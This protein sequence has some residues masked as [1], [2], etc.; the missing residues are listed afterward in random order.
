M[1]RELELLGDGAGVASFICLCVEDTMLHSKT[2]YTKPAYILASDI[3]IYLLTVSATRLRIDGSSRRD[4]KN[5]NH[6]VLTTRAM[7]GLNNPGWR[8]GIKKCKNAKKWGLRGTVQWGKIGDLCS[9]ILFQHN[10]IM[11]E[12]W[13]GGMWFIGEGRCSATAGTTG[14]Y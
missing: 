5:H 7:I 9:F 4:C 11:G 12:M 14:T 3:L 8:M 2:K 1:Q 10:S 13:E 6:C